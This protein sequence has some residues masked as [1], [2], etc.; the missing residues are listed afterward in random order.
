MSEQS[1]LQP[2]SNS[3]RDSLEEAVSSYSNSLMEDDSGV[4]W[5]LARGIDQVSAATFRLGAVDDP[6]PGHERFRGWLAIPYL[7]KDG[8]PLTVR[9]RCPVDHEH[10]GHGK[11]MT[12]PEDPARVFNVGA[13]HRAGDEIHLTEGELD[14]VILTQVGLH[15]CAIPGA[16]GF[17]G[18]HRRMLAGFNRVWVWGDP[19]EAGSMFVN[20]VSRMLRSAR[21][22][23]LRDGDVND[24]YLQ[25]GARRLLE[26]VENEAA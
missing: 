21:G 20:K 24:T 12:L 1:S 25:H 15:A 7:D 23:R 26:L 14:A 6:F 10:I 16:S 3:Q 9:F 19:D 2:L 17:Q 11:Y 18:H 5:L 13:I 22:V 8:A 4:D